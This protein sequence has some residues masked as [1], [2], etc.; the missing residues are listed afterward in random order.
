MQKP[1]LNGRL[2]LIAYEGLPFLFLQSISLAV[3]SKTKGLVGIGA[4]PNSGRNCKCRRGL[5]P[6][7]IILSIYFH[8]SR[9][10][11]LFANSPLHKLT[12]HSYVCKEI[13]ASKI[14][15]FLSFHKN[16]QLGVL[17]NTKW[18]SPVLVYS[19]ISKLQYKRNSHLCCLSCLPINQHVYCHSAWC[20]LLRC[21]WEGKRRNWDFCNRVVNQR[22]HWL[23]GTSGKGKDIRT[24]V[25]D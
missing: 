8:S 13:K 14:L 12:D 15:H 7:C 11:L 9:A 1:S 17:K 6:M 20:L 3:F 10:A 5:N 4:T 18:I 23:E 16:P 19:M 2:F 24:K 22:T 21:W 25:K